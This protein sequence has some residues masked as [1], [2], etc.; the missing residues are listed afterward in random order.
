MC[1]GTPV[2]CL[3]LSSFLF[4]C[5]S[6]H[7]SPSPC[8][9]VSVFLCACLYFSWFYSPLWKLDAHIYLGLFGVL[10]SSI[11]LC[12]SFDASICTRF[13][14]ASSFVPHPHPVIV[15]D[16]LTCFVAPCEVKLSS[17]LLLW[18]HISMYVLN[19]LCRFL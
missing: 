15:F 6:V 14:D 2:L 11:C 18:K 19:W 1:V 12:I 3:Y 9:S 7:L 8:L 17:F 4:F 10:L 16:Y 5:L 13:W